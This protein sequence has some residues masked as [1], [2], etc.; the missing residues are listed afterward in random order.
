[1]VLVLSPEDGY[2][3]EVTAL[4]RQHAGRVLGYLT[5]MGCER[6]LAEEITNDAFAVTWRNWARVGLYDEPEGY[7]F[8]IARNER[9][10]RQ[11]GH[12]GRSRE[13]DPDP[14]PAVRAAGD[15]HAQLVADRA[16]VQEALRQLPASQRE[17]MVLRY[18][19]DLTETAIARAMGI[20][21]GCVKR[22]ISEAKRRLRVL[23][24]DF[25]PQEEGDD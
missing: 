25:R 24:K 17:V 6:G 8:Q 1:M 19:A 2:D 12:E 7:V 4:C 23:L 3:D 5:G 15:D 14:R 21:V 18:V 9:R 20:S 16:A 13:L 11:P 10:K 22:Y